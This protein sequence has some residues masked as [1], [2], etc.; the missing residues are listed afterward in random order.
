M[1]L[2]SEGQK[3]IKKHEELRLVAYLDD[4][5]VPTI[6]YGHT[7]GVHLGMT[8]T[9]AEADT[10]F[11]EDSVPVELAINRYAKV[12]LTQNQ[13]DALGSFTFNEGIAALIGSTL[14]RLL[15][16]GDYAGAAN[17]FPKWNKIHKDGKLVIE[18]GLITRRK[19]EQTLFNT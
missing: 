17:E 18:P 11:D 8:C 12:T 19:N 10:F 4:A 13:F 7:K 9:E 3:A 14:I 5:G 1:R 2:S 6:G 16:G 15:N